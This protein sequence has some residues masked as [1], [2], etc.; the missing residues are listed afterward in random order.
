VSKVDAS[1]FAPFS[2]KGWVVGLPL[3]HLPDPCIAWPAPTHHPEPIA[4]AGTVVPDVPAFII[5][6]D[7]DLNV[8]PAES[9]ALT[10]MFPKSHVV[11]LTSSGHHV[12]FNS[13]GDCAVELI[14]NF[15]KALDPGDT[16]CAPDSPIVW[17]GVA[18]FPRRAHGAKQV[19]RVAAA[20]VTDAIRRS[21]RQDVPNGVG[22]RGGTYKGKFGDSG[23]TLRLKRAR[24]A[25]NL[26]VTGKV[27]YKG[28]MTVDARVRLAGA[29]KGRVH[30]RGL[31]AA[32]G[33]TTLKITGKVNGRK[34][35]LSVPAE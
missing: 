18:E 13:R 9:H 34:V 31:W 4:P 25:R 26:A 14:V 35:S 21:F 12:L 16:S 29:F 22:L 3:G 27:E 23:E 8:P 2:V 15:I 19:A 20:T 32:P 30:V 24:F 5:S 7:L 17:A 28:Y 33:A 1:L 11:D 10:A 6:G